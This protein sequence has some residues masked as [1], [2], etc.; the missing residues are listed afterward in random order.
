MTQDLDL[1]AGLTF[2]PLLNALGCLDGQRRAV[3]AKYTVLRGRRLH[4]VRDGALEEG[5]RQDFG[6]VT[7][8]LRADLEHV[9]NG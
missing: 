2:V 6:R 8:L 1:L 5:Q 4:V 3:Q 9:F 7:A